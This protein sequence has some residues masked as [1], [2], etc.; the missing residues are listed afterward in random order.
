VT[1]DLPVIWFVCEDRS[2]LF[3]HLLSVLFDVGAARLEED[4]FRHTQDNLSA[5]EFH[6]KCTFF[7]LDAEAFEQSRV[8]IAPAVE[9]CFEILDIVERALESTSTLNV[10]VGE[11]RE[12]VL[13]ATFEI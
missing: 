2:D 13:A 11:F 7:D 9:L 6:G 12:V 8:K 10:F 5:L 4:F 1:S 3:D